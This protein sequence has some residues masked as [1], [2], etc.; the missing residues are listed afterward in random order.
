M[1]TAFWDKVK[2]QLEQWKLDHA[3]SPNYEYELRYVDAIK[4][5]HPLTKY[6]EPGLPDVNDDL[7]SVPYPKNRQLRY[8]AGDTPSMFKNL[9]SNP[10]GFTE[11]NVT[12]TFNSHG[13]R[14]E[15]LD[16]LAK[17]KVLIV[18]DSHTFGVGLD[19]TQ[20]W[21][22]QF[23]TILPI[24]T[25]VINLSI[26]GAS[27]DYI[28]RALLQSI[29]TIKPNVV[30][31]CYTYD[32]RRETQMIATQGKITQINP[33]VPNQLPG[34]DESKDEFRSWFMTLN[35]HSNQY[36]FD[37]NREMVRLICY[38]AKVPLIEST[39][40]DMLVIQ[41]QMSKKLGYVDKARD[42]EHFGP[43]VHKRLAEQIYKKWT[44]IK[45]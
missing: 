17:Y 6:F 20:T 40:I 25:N 10:N 22:H 35:H 16:V 45:N 3:V 31:V 5:D 21:T 8:W 23:K 29:D 36:N 30:I 12:Y 33:T 39:V 27:M 2:Q 42:G 11:D 28:S 9:Q 1:L 14:G 34:D 37:K 7:I 24:K 13:F 18:G 4:N 44:L 15:D 32:C 19:D 43:N 41:K 26:A 38:K